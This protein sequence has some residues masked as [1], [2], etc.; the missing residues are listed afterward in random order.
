MR[1][2]GLSPHLQTPC[3]WPLGGLGDYIK[4]GKLAVFVTDKHL[5]SATKV[6]ATVVPG[7]EVS[8]QK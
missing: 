3:G 2:A 8:K 1:I 6:V 5:P 7:W 4:A